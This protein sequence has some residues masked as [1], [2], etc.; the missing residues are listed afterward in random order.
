MK[1]REKTGVYMQDLTEFNETVLWTTKKRFYLGFERI[2]ICLFTILGIFIV[3][4][5]SALLSL[6][7]KHLQ[8]SIQR[9]P[10]G[11]P[12][13]PTVELRAEHTKQFLGTMQQYVSA[14]PMEYRTGFVLHA[15]WHLAITFPFWKLWM[16]PC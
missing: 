6:Q 16:I 10:F 11:G 9:D 7:M 5:I 8:F 4:R 12:L 15:H 13:I 1:E 3:N 2:Q 14:R